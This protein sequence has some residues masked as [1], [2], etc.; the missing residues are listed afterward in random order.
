M[1]EK[2]FRTVK[3]CNAAEPWPVAFEMPEKAIYTI[4]KAQKTLGG[5]GS[6]P[7]RRWDNLQ[8]SPIL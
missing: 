7:D 5:Y 1:L 8:R 3:I 2:F 6:T 4:Y